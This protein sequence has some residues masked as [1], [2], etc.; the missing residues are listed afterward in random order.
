MD[1]TTG[2]PAPGHDTDVASVVEELA[3][4]EFTPLTPAEE[5][6]APEKLLM[7]SQTACR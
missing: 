4:F 3:D 5:P 6:E 2:T 1:E 7:M